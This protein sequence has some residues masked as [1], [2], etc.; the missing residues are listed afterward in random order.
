LGSP[1]QGLERGID[2]IDHRTKIGYGRVPFRR[3]PD[4]DFA[5]RFLS[6]I[7]REYGSYR[8]TQEV[9]TRGFTSTF[10]AERVARGGEGS[11]VAVVKALDFARDGVEPENPEGL[12]VEFLDSARAQ[13]RAGRESPYFARVYQTGLVPDG[14]YVC[15]EH[16]PRSV[17]RL[18]DMHARIGPKQLFS[19]ITQ[20]VQG[21]GDLRRISERPHGN[22]KPSNVLLRGKRLGAKRSVALAD[23]LPAAQLS[24]NHAAEDLEAV[25][26]M[27]FQLV[28]RTE[29]SGHIVF[30]VDDSP[31]WPQMGGAG[32]RLRA[33]CNALLDPDAEPETKFQRVEQLLAGRRRARAALRIVTVLVAIAAIS[34]AG[35]LYVRKHP[36]SL[37]TLGLRPRTTPTQPSTQRSIAKHDHGS[38]TSVVDGGG[39]SALNLGGGAHEDEVH[40]DR[41][42]LPPI[43]IARANFEYPSLPD[44]VMRRA[45]GEPGPTTR[46]ITIKIVTTSATTGPATRTVI[47]ATTQ[48]TSERS[49]FATIGALASAS[50]RAATWVKSIT[51]NTTSTATTKAVIE[52]ATTGPTTQRGSASTQVVV[53]TTRPV[54]VNVP[55]VYAGQSYAQFVGAPVDF[56]INATNQ[57]LEYDVVDLPDGLKLD[58]TVGVVRGKM[59]RSGE[60]RLRARARNADGWG[61]YEVIKLSFGIAESDR[62]L[63]ANLLA[64]ACES[65][66]ELRGCERRLATSRDG[67]ADAQK[68]ADDDPG[69][70]SHWTRVI[71]IEE[72]KEKEAIEKLTRASV[73]LRKLPDEV[74]ESGR[75]AFATDHQKKVDEVQWLMSNLAALSATESVK[76]TVMKHLG[77]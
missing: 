43:E 3:E 76:S 75:T 41:S 72:R 29:A 60:R 61:S 39:E 48:P 10:L 17:Q 19:I 4:V 55:Q 35:A 28:T 69:G 67:L 8:T 31:D 33:L 12:I 59:M 65:I 62:T 7:V 70:V 68:R 27:L 40:A 77:R 73:S 58:R 23:P 49:I 37:A 57:P 56:Q 30:P 54:Q 34:A 1:E 16:C 20:V 38:A 45:T 25:G 2:G 15:S 53:A 18:L 5:V 74:K 51:P 22:I 50:M 21:L 64:E 11:A 63:A 66:E 26:R 47:A 13:Q 42:A 52:I 6:S 24:S 9:A 71:E 44:G 46:S 32:K 36:I 14:A